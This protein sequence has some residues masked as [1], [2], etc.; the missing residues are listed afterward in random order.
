MMA[1]FLVSTLAIAFV[2]LLACAIVAAI[3]NECDC[4]NTCPY[5]PTKGTAE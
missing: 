2:Y 4:P 1:F 3:F 5:H